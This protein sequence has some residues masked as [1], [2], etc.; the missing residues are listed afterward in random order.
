MPVTNTDIDAMK[1]AYRVL[2]APLTASAHFI[3]QCYRR[4]VKRWHPDLYS[5]GTEQYAEATQMSTLVN[6]AY[7]RV[8]R[9][10]LRYYVESAPGVWPTVGAAAR[11]HIERPVDRAEFWIMF[12]CCA[13][14]GAFISLS[15]ILRLRDPLTQDSNLIIAVVSLGV[16]IS[17]GLGAAYGGDQFWH[18]IFRRWWLWRVWP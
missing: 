1:Q 16:V 14:F 6:D 9:A 5:P 12:V 4:M 8:E 17:C 10:P 7:A 15:N 11:D 13:L 2:D 3:K 18:S